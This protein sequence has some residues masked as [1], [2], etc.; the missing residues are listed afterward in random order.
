MISPEALVNLNA[1]L[2]QGKAAMLDSMRASQIVQREADK[3]YRR[4]VPM[5]SPEPRL[6]AI[7]ARTL[8]LECGR[9]DLEG[10][11]DGCPIRGFYT[12]GRV[13]NGAD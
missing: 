11:I 13:G 6:T 7:G 2:R 3:F 8:C 10:H 5:V 12:H 1:A 9:T 4:V